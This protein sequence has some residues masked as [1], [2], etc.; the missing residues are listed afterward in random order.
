MQ[1]SIQETDEVSKQ[2]LHENFRYI[3]VSIVILSDFLSIRKKNNHLSFHS[4]LSLTHADL[5]EKYPSSG[6]QLLYILWFRPSIPVLSR[7]RAIFTDNH[8]P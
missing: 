2:K 3:V 6:A 8:P 7:Y 4:K 5:Q 1:R